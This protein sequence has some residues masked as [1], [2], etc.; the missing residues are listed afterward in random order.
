MPPSRSPAHGAAPHFTDPLQLPAR[1]SH[2]TTVA[3][4]IPAD[5][6]RTVLLLANTRNMA[7]PTFITG[8]KPDE[9][10]TDLPCRN[11]VRGRLISRRGRS[12]YDVFQQLHG[13]GYSREEM[14]DVLRIPAVRN[15]LYDELRRQHNTQRQPQCPG[16]A[17]NPTTTTPPTP[18]PEPT[19][20][21]AQ[22]AG[23]EVICYYHQ[24]FG[25]RAR[26]C[27]P[28]CSFAQSCYYCGLQGSLHKDRRTPCSHVQ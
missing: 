9:P 25:T 23:T 1:S 28:P 27:R 8:D 12:V 26:Q 4:S 19:L 13:P 2:T 3:V 7:R 22:T 21:T 14:D 20:T 15:S 10:N 16:G 11:D 17:V 24:E 5:L 18:Q 6:L